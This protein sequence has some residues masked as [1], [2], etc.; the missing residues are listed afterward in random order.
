MADENGRIVNSD[1]G[2]PI[3]LAVR[4]PGQVAA[5]RTSGVTIK[6]GARSGNPN[7]DPASGRFGAGG[8]KRVTAQG[9]DLI[10]ES[11]PRSDVP[12]GVSQEVW[13]RRLD[14]V[15]DA[16]REMDDM[17]VGDVKEFL[18]GKVA[19]LSAVNAEQFVKDVREQRLDDL[20]D[21]LDHQL[22][23]TVSGMQR[24]K[25]YVRLVA[26]KGFK[27]RVFAGLNDD[28]VIKLV[29]RLEGRGFDPKDLNTN[30]IRK[31][32]NE[33][34]RTRLEQLYGEGAPSNVNPGKKE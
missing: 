17:D 8:N 6:R 9:N 18:K 15:R 20:L 31:V 16:A 19:D 4:S 27:D 12:Q 21:I 34:R 32:K 26:P 30:I 25:R 11:L 22:R 7:F 1:E 2:I 33:D 13:E 14:M 28:E 5:Q 29:K 24:S 10:V 23:A 3:L